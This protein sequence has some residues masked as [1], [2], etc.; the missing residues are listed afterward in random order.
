MFR[1]G[2][3]WL[4]S[5]NRV[6]VI[7]YSVLAESLFRYACLGGPFLNDIPSFP[8]QSIS[9]VNKVLFRLGIDINQELQTIS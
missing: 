6:A 8:R 3:F 5:F 4:Q 2:P 1:V 7:Q 9:K